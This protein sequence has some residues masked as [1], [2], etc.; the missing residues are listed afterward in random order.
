MGAN[1]LSEEKGDMPTKCTCHILVKGDVPTEHASRILVK[2]EGVVEAH[3][4]ST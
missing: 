3:L 4:S 1:L 2:G